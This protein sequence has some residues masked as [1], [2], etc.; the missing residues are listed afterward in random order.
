MGCFKSK[1]EE[2]KRPR[3]IYVDLLNE[4]EIITQPE[5]FCG[6]TIKTTHYSM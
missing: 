4:G 6:N 5:I 3:K 2:I 1:K